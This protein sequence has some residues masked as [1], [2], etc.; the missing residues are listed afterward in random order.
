MAKTKT[1][2]ST[3][4]KTYRPGNK[5]K[6]IRKTSD[7][8]VTLDGLLAAV[9]RDPEDIKA[10]LAL[11]DYYNNNRMENKIIAAIESL[12]KLYPFADRYLRGLY[13]R[14]LAIG[15]SHLGRFVDSEKAALRGLEDFPEALDFYYVLSYLK[16]SLREYDEAVQAA[17]KYVSLRNKIKNGRKKVTEFSATGAHATQLYNFLGVALREKKEFDK[18]ERA[19]LEAVEADSG[20]YLP[21]LNLAQLYRTRNLPQKATDIVEKGLKKCRQ[22]QELRMLKESFEKRV[23]LSACLMVKDEE[24]LLPGCLDSVRDWVDEIIIVDTGSTDR[25]IEIAESYGAKIFHQPWEG[26]FSKHRNYSI[27]QATC[28]WILIIDADERICQEDVPLLVEHLNRGQAPII[29][30]NVYNVYRD[31]NQSTT[32]L[33]SERLFRRELNLRYDGIVHNQLKLPAGVPILKTGVKLEHLG[34]DLTPEKMEKKMAR[35]RALLEK[36]LE[37]NQDN[38]FALFNLAQLYRSGYDGFKEVNAPLVFKWAGRAVEITDPENLKERHIHLMCLDQLAWTHFYMKN[39]DKALD[40]SRRALRIKP[41]YLDPLL[42]LGHIHSQLK[43]YRKAEE[44]YQNYLKAQAVFDPSSETESIILIHPDSRANAYYS[45]GLMAEMQ[46]KFDDAKK[47][48]RETLKV[49]PEFLEANTLLGKLYL[50]DN[51]FTE[52]EKYFLKQL[53]SGNQSKEAALGVAYIHLQ[54]KDYS[55]AR[56]YYREA[57]EMDPEDPVTLSRYGEFCLVAG[58]EE[59]ALELFQRAVQ[60]GG[61]NENIKKRMADTYLKTGRYDEAINLYKKVLRDNNE[62]ADILNDLGN[63]YYR[64]ELFEEA[65]KYYIRTLEVDGGYTIAYRNRGLTRARLSKAKEAII[66]LEKYLQLNPDQHEIL[67]IIG[68]LYSKLGEFNTALA[69]YEKFLSFRPADPLALF[70][71]SECYLNMGHKDSAILGYRRILQIDP[72][73]KP[74]QQRLN[75]LTE[76]MEKA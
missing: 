20:N 59:E 53:A 6:T 74:A 43:E 62:A 55:Q 3:R 15:Y 71:L 44:A 9:R 16:L 41:N 8:T 35:S 29:A 75:R 17:E 72:H 65:E 46:E 70:N 7:R 31:K 24:E 12:E 21:Y 48:Y 34:Y 32:F 54:Q 47:Y 37:E 61:S 63:C 5:S 52:A 69:Y 42:L 56:R 51:E 73:F 49:N 60:R 36:Q 39:Y 22:V 1:K 45:L 25:T 19:F 38:A 18:S 27:E 26:N 58:S 2:K 57:L 4:K 68:D 33:P 66:D 10:V 50:K 30:I 11:G 28:D 64:Q 13:N 23:S 67:H 40:Y 76:V 14:L